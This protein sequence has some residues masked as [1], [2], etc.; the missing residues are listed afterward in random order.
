MPGFYYG[1]VQRTLGQD[2]AIR[3]GMNWTDLDAEIRR[4]I[5]AMPVADASM[6]DERSQKYRRDGAHD[7]SARRTRGVRGVSDRWPRARDRRRSAIRARCSWIRFAAIV[8]APKTISPS[9]ASGTRR[10]Q[11]PR[12]YRTSTIRD[13]ARFTTA[14]TDALGCSVL[15]TAREASERCAR[16]VATRRPALLVLASTYPRWSGDPSPVRARA[17]AATRW[18][19][20][21][22]RGRAGCA[23]APAIARCS[24]AYR[25]ALSLRAAALETLVNDGGIVSIC[26]AS[27]EMAARADVL[28]RQ[29]LLRPACI[30]TIGPRSCTR[31]G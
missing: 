27:V 25:R 4:R 23:G 8:K 16:E 20:R 12:W 6:V 29:S 7:R 30:R 15:A 14:L 5:D 22:R 3:P 19:V 31:I 17:R 21:R 9:D 13:R 1:R 11:V 26:A 18:H 10:L 28:P 2:V 24:M